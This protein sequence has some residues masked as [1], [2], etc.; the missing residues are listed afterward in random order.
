MLSKAKSFP[1][2]ESKALRAGRNRP[3]TASKGF[4]LDGITY[5]SGEL[6]HRGREHHPIQLEGWYK[7]VPNTAIGSFQISGDID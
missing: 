7:P 4:E 3:N 1:N 2:I 5:V 6:T